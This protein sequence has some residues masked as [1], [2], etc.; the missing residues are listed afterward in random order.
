MFTEYKFD[1]KKIGGLVAQKQAALKANKG[2][3]DLLGYGLG[4]VS[5][6]LAKDPGRYLD[7][8][9]YWWALKDVLTRAGYDYGEEGDPVLVQAY[10]GTSDLQTMVMADRFRTE[11]LEEN[12]VGTCKFRLDTE[13]SEYLLFDADMVQRLAV[14]A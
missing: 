9:P 13:G 1:S 6:R 3:S 5:R 14:A 7:Y 4:V 10:R 12:Q 8:G 11:F 2:L